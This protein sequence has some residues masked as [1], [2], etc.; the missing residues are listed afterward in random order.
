MQGTLEAE[1]KEIRRLKMTGIGKKLYNI[2]V[3][4][5][6]WIK[7]ET[8]RLNQDYSLTEEEIEN[9]ESLESIMSSLEGLLDE[10]LYNAEV[11]L[12][13]FDEETLKIFTVAFEI[14]FE[15]DNDGLWF[16]DDPCI[17][18]IPDSLPTLYVGIICSG[19]FIEGGG[20]AQCDPLST[21]EEPARD[22]VNQFKKKYIL[23]RSKSSS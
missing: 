4:K 2:I 8:R 11:L 5:F 1:K 18:L 15:K 22:T 20:G 21:N 7:K 19:Y 23:A 10:T 13:A 12:N 9:G 14:E 6:D 3:S 16:C 17:Y